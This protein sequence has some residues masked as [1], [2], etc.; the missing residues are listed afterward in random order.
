[1]CVI[2]HDNLGPWVAVKDGV[3][4]GGD[5]AGRRYQWLGNLGTVGVQGCHDDLQFLRHAFIKQ[6]M[7]IDGDRQSVGSRTSTVLL[8]LLV[9]E[10]GVGRYQRQL[11]QGRW[12][13]EIQESL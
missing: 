8:Y 12:V 5:H 6:S 13:H 4:V 7:G 10:H 11:V 1:M 2:H 3:V 9:L